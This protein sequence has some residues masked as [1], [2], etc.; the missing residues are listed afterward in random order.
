VRS[1]KRPHASYTICDE[2]KAGQLMFASK[3]LGFVVAALS[4]APGVPDRALF[5][6]RRC[7]PPRCG[8]KPMAV[9][10]DGFTWAFERQPG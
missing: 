3:I 2:E 9:G 5:L 6:G 1:Q 8:G 4:L 7:L 10:S